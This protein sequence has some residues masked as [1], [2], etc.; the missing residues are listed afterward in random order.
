MILNEFMLR[1]P[2]LESKPAIFAGSAAPSRPSV[3]S[4][5]YLPLRFDQ[6]VMIVRP[7]GRASTPLRP[8]AMAVICGTGH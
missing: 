2:L 5:K 8:A 3:L 1:A 4:H 6:L 7:A